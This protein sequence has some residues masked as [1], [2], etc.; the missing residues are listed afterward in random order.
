MKRLRTNAE[1]VVSWC[2]AELPHQKT[3]RDKHTANENMFQIRACDWRQKEEWKETFKAEKVKLDK[4]GAIDRPAK[5][6]KFTAFFRMSIFL[7]GVTV[8]R[9]NDCSIWCHKIKQEA[10]NV[11]DVFLYRGLEQAPGCHMRK[12]SRIWFSFDSHNVRSS[13]VSALSQFLQHNA[14]GRQFVEGTRLHFGGETIW[15]RSFWRW[16]WLE[17][18]RFFF[19][20]VFVCIFV[21]ILISWT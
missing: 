4:K 19:S 20:S 7:A 6:Q 18:T 10:S 15:N 14:R 1:P 16:R 11:F 3:W 2:E 8:P 13:F 5:R 9:D 12:S 17:W 21:N